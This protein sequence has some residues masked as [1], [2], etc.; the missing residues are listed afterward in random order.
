MTAYDVGEPVGDL[1]GVAPGWRPRP[2]PAPAAR[3]RRAAAGRGRC[4]RARPPPRRRAAART[5]SSSARALSTSGTLTSTCGSRVITDG[6]LG[7]RLA[8]RGHP[9]QHVQRGQDAVAGGGVVAHD[10]VAGLLAAEGEAARPASPRARSGR[11]PWSAARRC[12]RRASPA[13]S[14]GCSSRSPRRCPWRSAPASRIASARIARS[15][16]PSTTS[17]VVVD[18]QAAVGVAVERE[19]DVGAVL[20]HGRA[21]RLEVGGAAAVV[22]VEAV[23]LGVD[24]D[25]LGAGVRAARAGRPRR[26]RPRRSRARP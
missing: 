8:G 7:E 20:E 6:Q 15:W 12:R 26:R 21:Q 22:D 5:A 2:S 9:L 3:C 1:V 17:P 25:H 24:R 23:G 13:R 4:R 14:R 16:S 10:H 18:G 11:R 19:A